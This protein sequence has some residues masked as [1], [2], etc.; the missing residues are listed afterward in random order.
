[1]PLDLDS[2][3]QI[4]KVVGEFYSVYYHRQDGPA[5]RAG[6]L[7][8][9]LRPGRDPRRRPLARDASNTVW[10][11]VTPTFVYRALKGLPLV[12]DERRRSRAATS[13]TSTTSSTACCCARRDGARRRRLQ[14]RERRRDDDPR[15]R[16][17]R[18]RARGKRR[19][20]SSTG[21]G[22]RG[23][24]RSSASARRR[25]RSSELGFEAKV[26]LRDG[27]ERTVEWTR[28]NLELIDRCIARHAEEMARAGSPVDELVSPPV[29]TTGP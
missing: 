29:S 19:A 8:E 6:A 3:Y 16:G 17:A 27:L 23:T 18:Q 4:S 9:R 26:E 15:A 21:R 7:P 25:R 13:S 5:D 20:R 12:V 28:A 1:M 22:G 24:T 2:P 14:P 11:N 10:R